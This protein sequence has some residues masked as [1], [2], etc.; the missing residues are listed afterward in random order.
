VKTDS[1]WIQQ[2]TD[3]YNNNRPIEWI[4]IHEVP[5][6]VHFN[7][8]RHM[9]AGLQ[10]QNCHGPVETMDKVYQFGALNMGWCMSCH[11]GQTTPM[12]ILQKYHPGA[13]D[14]HQQVAS[15]NCVTCHY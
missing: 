7:H 8:S 11:R 2:I 5:D 10:C 12:E 6:H 14:P 9:T 4:R 1:P 3:A 13:E 15:T